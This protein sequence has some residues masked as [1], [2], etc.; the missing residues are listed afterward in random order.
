MFLLIFQ[1]IICI[2][3]REVSELVKL[4]IVLQF[5]FLNCTKERVTLFYVSVLSEKLIDFF[6]CF[7]FFCNILPQWAFCLLFF[8]NNK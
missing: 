2:N 5:K 8:M 3:L 1:L 6:Q 7:K 4:R